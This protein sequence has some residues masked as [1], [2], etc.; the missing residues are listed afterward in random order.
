[1]SSLRFKGDFASLNKWAGQLE[2]APEVLPVISRN[3][4]EAGI[5]LIKDGWDKQAD[6]YGKPWAPKKV[7]DGRAVLVGKTAR[8]KGGWH[9]TR[10]DR[11]GFAIAPSVDYG[12]FH[13]SGTRY[14]PARKM[15][16][17]GDLPTVWRDE[18]TAVAN[19]ILMA[20][21]NG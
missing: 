1:M 2:T 4:A 14:F 8:L 3:M 21:F 6:P 20:H 15:F 13:Q 5:G 11:R 10:A 19:E 7:A 16:P 9:T 18:F 17:D 12:V